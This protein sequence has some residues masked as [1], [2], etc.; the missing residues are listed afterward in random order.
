LTI[1]ATAIK[2]Y[3]III[4]F[5]VRKDLRRKLVSPQQSI[6]R[7]TLVSL[8]KYSRDTSSFQKQLARLRDY[9]RTAYQPLIIQSRL[10]LVVII[11]LN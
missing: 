1:A 7:R 9:S 2:K 5:L 4:I 11:N 6:R 8:C 3:L 10:L